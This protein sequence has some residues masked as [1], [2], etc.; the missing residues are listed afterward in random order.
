MSDAT[1]LK[2]KQT[3]TRQEAG[4]WLSSVARMLTTGEG[5]DVDLAG[6]RV[7]LHVADQIRAEI[8]IEAGAGKYEIDIELSWRDTSPA[9]GAGT[10]PPPSAP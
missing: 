6:E 10:T 1:T 3:V 2:K 8:E 9:G 5:G 7:T 4:E